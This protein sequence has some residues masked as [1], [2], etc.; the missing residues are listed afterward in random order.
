VFAKC[1]DQYVTN[2][3]PSEEYRQVDNPAWFM[4]LYRNALFNHW[5]GLSRKCS[6]ST[7]LEQASDDTDTPAPASMWDAIA[8]VSDELKAVMGIL[9]T[10]PEA[11]LE[12]IWRELSDPECRWSLNTKLRRMAK[13]PMGVDLVR[14]LRSL[15]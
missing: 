3:R 14:E 10:A 6:R 8:Q 1:V 11:T 4:A 9:V 5:N 2:P 12:V 7:D 13:L 15:L